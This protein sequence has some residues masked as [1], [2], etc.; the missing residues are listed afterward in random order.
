MLRR[1]G[2][3]AACALLLLASCVSNQGPL[4]EAPQLV[5]AA[6]AQVQAGDYAAAL[7]TLDPVLGE[8]C[9][10]RLLDRRDLAHAR[11]WFGVGEPWDAYLILERFSD[12]HPLSAL[13]PQAVELIWSVGKQLVESDGG[14]LF[15]WSDRTAGRIV[16][17]HLITRHPDTRRLADAL[18]I[19]GDMAFAEEDYELAQARY[20]DI[21]LDRPDSDWR[22][23]AKY[24]FAMSIVAGLRG[25]EYDL[26]RM[27]HAV[28]ELRGFLKTEPESPQMLAEAERAV[29]QVLSWQVQRHVEVV[30]YYRRLDNLEGQ[31]HHARLA[32]QEEFRGVP[33]FEEALVLRASVEAEAAARQA[34]SEAAAAAPG[35]R[36]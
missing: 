12:V 25:P 21:I 28:R 17:E 29:E 22:F 30:G 14:F 32:T 6:E 11:A 19:L 1:S 27:Q 9:P 13:R 31:L 2:N 26:D 15:F 5:E 36:P 8:G 10:A 18:R 3:A 7:N 23:Y 34:A 4:P 16:L 24:R 20:R 33:G 35:S